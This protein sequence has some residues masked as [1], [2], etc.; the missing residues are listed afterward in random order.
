M[1]LPNEKVVMTFAQVLIKTLSMV[2][3]LKLA[4]KSFSVEEFAYY[5]QFLNVNQ[6]LIL[7]SG[8]WCTTGVVSLIVSNEFN[9]KEILSTSVIT[10][11]LTSIIFLI[12][13]VTLFVFFPT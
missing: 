12:V 13:I 11:S 7:L 4:A 9:D 6:V 2:F 8:A 10:S 3:L 5:S 1:K